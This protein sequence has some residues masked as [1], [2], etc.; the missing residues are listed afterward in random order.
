MTNR[1]SGHSAHV[2]AI[3]NT[4]GEGI[5]TVDTSQVIRLAN[6]EAE[7]IFG[8]QP[9]GLY[10]VMLQAL[11]PEKYRARHQAGFSRAVSSEELQTSGEYLELEG[12]RKDGEV[13]PLEIRFISLVVEGERFY[14]ASVRD[15]TVR[16]RAQALRQEAEAAAT[17][18]EQAN[19]AKSAFLANMSHE[20]RSPLNAIIGFSQL[21]QRSDE[22]GE[23]QRENVR[24]I[25]R[26]GEHLLALIN[27]VLE[28]SRIEA[29]R[30]VLEEGAFNLHELIH[31]LVD[32][33][34]VRVRDKALRLSCVLGEEVPQYVHADE[35]KLRQILINLLGN[36]V[37]FTQKGGVHVEAHSTTERLVVEVA[38][39]GPGIA[40]EELETLFDAFVQTQS[41]RKAQTGT[42]LGLAISQRFAQLM[43]GRIEVKSAVDEG[44]TFRLDQPLTPAQASEVPS[45]EVDRRIV[46]LAEGQGEWRILAVDDQTDTR[47][48]LRQVL[49]PLGF[50]VREAADGREGI[51]VWREWQPQLIW[52]DVRMPVMDGY[53]ATRRIKESA[54]GDETKIIALT[55]SAFEEDRRKAFDAGCDGFVPKPFRERELF[56]KMTAHLGV[57]FVYA[58][59]E[60]S[61][62]VTI[63]LDGEALGVMPES[64]RQ[65]VRQ[66]ARTADGEALDELIEAI[67]AS[68]VL[69]AQQLR[70]MVQNFRFKELMRLTSEP[71][72]SSS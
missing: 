39:S 65:A 44:S 27:D 58:D 11:M 70:E 45:A 46:G 71:P 53:E 16:K 52:M 38:D 41:G 50:Q 15:I 42:G 13:F 37:K 8:Y 32:M 21:L 47:R 23:G 19:Q 28:M 40:P 54:G 20:L 35:G 63:E 61:S 59:E 51:Q 36:A 72:G 2:E 31:S 66:A 18:A 12:L 6:Q 5:I 49:E 26:S 48:L 22:V 34:R 69:L 67:P 57:T 43:G 29:G 60:V 3:L 10:G 1:L 33:F 68:D 24:V 64:W 62:E 30:T 56:D 55:A 4:V 14:T 17:A 7:R 9:D 25:G